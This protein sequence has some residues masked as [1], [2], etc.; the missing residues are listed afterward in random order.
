MVAALFSTL[1]AS[2][3][4]TAE[5]IAAT[6]CRKNVCGDARAVP[7]MVESCVPGAVDSL[8]S[9]LSIR[10]N[11]VKRAPVDSMTCVIWWTEELIYVT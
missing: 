2:A 10:T 3:S 5:D 9:V 1:R 4:T 11:G 8:P 7:Y 6:W